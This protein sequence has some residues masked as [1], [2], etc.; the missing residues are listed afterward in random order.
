[1]GKLVAMLLLTT[2]LVKGEPLFF[3]QGGGSSSRAFGVS[4][5]QDW[6]GLEVHQLGI[7]KGRSEKCHEQVNVNNQLYHIVKVQPLLKVSKG[8]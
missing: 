3:P 5:E 7:V 6:L 1:M 8:K 2:S 4:P